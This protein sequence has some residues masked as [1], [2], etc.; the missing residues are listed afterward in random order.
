MNSMER[1]N[2]C[3]VEQRMVYSIYYMYT[4]VLPCIGEGR[5]LLRRDGSGRRTR[6]VI[7]IR[8]IDMGIYTE[9]IT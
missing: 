4:L 5:R 8:H 7:H 1:M 2:E 9:Y 3:V 6:D